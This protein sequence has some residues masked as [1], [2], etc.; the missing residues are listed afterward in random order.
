MDLIR[1]DLEANKGNIKSSL[2][3][4]G[5]RISH[6]FSTSTLKRIIGFPFRL[7][8]KFVTEWI[9][10]FELKDTTSIG[11]GFQIWHCGHGTVIG[12]AVIIGENVSIRHNT[13]IGGKGFDGKGKRP[14]IGNNVSIGPHCVIIGEITIGD[15]AVIG[16]GSVV[17]KDVLPNDVVVG[18]PAKP[19]GKRK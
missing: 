19:I 4:I 2:L 13:T 6:W 9:F 8:Y 17:V 3:V 11:A 14:V 5:F 10:N 7:F 16:A 18:N 15:N 1:K 12:P